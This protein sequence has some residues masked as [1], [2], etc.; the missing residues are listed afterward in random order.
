MR[1]QPALK[2]GIL[3]ALGTIGGRYLNPPILSLFSTL[4][5]LFFLSLLLIWTRSK[6]LTPFII[7]AIMVGGATR[8]GVEAW[9]LPPHH[10]SKVF[11]SGYVRLEGTISSDPVFDGYMTRFKLASERIYSRGR[12]IPA[13]GG[14]LVKAKVPLQKFH[15]GHRLELKG[16]LSDPPSAA[17][18]GQF[19]YRQY[20]RQQ[21]IYKLISVRDPTKIKLLG[22]KGNPI[23]LQITSP[24]RRFLLSSIDSHLRGDP[25][26]L[27]RGILMGE[28]RGLSK[29]VEKAFSDA[30]VIHVLAVSGLH[31][32]LVI[33]IFLTLFRSLRLGFRPSVLVTLLVLVA[34]CGVAQFRPSV[35]RSSIMG[36]LILGGLC[37]QRKTDLLNSIGAAGLLIL[38]L[39][40]QAIFDIGFQ[41]SFVATLSI[42]CL[43]PK[44]KELS[45]RSLREG[46]ILRRWLWGSLLVSF[47]AQLGIM[48]LLICHF[49]HIP[50]ISPLSNLLVVPLIGVELALGLATSA[51]SIFSLK[52]GYIPSAA[53]WL[54]LKGTLFL[55]GLLSKI[56]FSSISVPHPPQV[57][58]IFYYLLFLPLAH[59]K[60][61]F[62]ARKALLILTLLLA[63]LLIWRG[64]LKGEGKLKATFL[65]VGDG[66]SA[67]I[68]LPRGGTIIVDGGGERRGFNFGER[69]V[70]PYLQSTGRRRIDLLV[71]TYP[72]EVNLAGLIP[73]LRE[74][75]PKGVIDGGATF[76]SAR[77]LEFLREMEREDI[78]H[79]SLEKRLIITSPSG[80][81]MEFLPSPLGPGMALRV[82]YKETSIL[83]IGGMEEVTHYSLSDSESKIIGIANPGELNTPFLEKVRPRLLIASTFSPEERERFELL[84]ISPL[85]LKQEGAINVTS[86]GEEWRLRK[87]LTTGK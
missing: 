37:L 70:I 81:K 11:S 57:V 29:R 64:A 68:H 56:P 84:G 39:N 18:P 61:S 77:Y 52:L 55:T 58:I 22:H 79:F 2:T 86:D 43:Y 6:I 34:Y 28:K 76:P 65:A 49:H 1:K 50:L 8:Y 42:V 66:S 67:V 30:G 53:N 31:V 5:L 7:L 9:L 71:V 35:V 36:G 48:P 45:P 3:F 75:R 19:N 25:A 85:S 87:Y 23:R 24:L 12:Q 60:S 17:N 27:L 51:L 69:V 4:V 74:Y 78:S 15:Y 72:Y 83:L 59:L 82:S 54:F 32:G 10:L 16:W 80:V 41:L 73:I 20:L 44:L 62:Q 40:P 38:L 63:N 14:I 13:T 26:H 21:G 33:T 47:S 46:G